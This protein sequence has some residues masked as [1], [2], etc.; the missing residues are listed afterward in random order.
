MFS[1][2]RFRNRNADP[3]QAVGGK[4]PNENDNSHYDEIEEPPEKMGRSELDD[5]DDESS[6]CLPLDLKNFVPKHVRKDLG[7]R[8]LLFI[9]YLLLFSHIF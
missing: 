3:A 4:R 2:F 9:Y 7:E 6:V 1:G 5:S 8:P